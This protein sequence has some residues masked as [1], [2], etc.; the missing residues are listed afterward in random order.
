MRT[1]SND[2][3][4]EFHLVIKNYKKYQMKAKKIIAI[5]WISMAVYS[6]GDKNNTK[7]GGNEINIDEVVNSTSKDPNAKGENKCL[8]DYQS[9][10]DALIS[11]EDVLKVTGF[12]KAVMKTKLNKI[13]KDPGTH[14]FLFEFDNKRK[15]YIKQL[16]RKLEKEDIIAIRN[17]KPMSLTNFEQSYRALTDAEEQKAKEAMKDITEGN[18]D[19]PNADKAMKQAQQNMSKE[20]VN[21]VGGAIIDELKNVSQ[22]YVKVDGLGDAA[23]WNT[24][25]QELVVLQKGVQFEIMANINDNTETN[26]AAA[27]QL[28]KIVLD[29]CK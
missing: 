1:Q 14:E 20:D 21:K 5:L 25:T 7:Q 22:A 28:A 19:D 27:V 10:Y 15:Q 4:G 26:K 2:Y 8:L 23:V 11:A 3:F 29:K 24:Q 17:I 13:L 9:K 6:C 18:S 16:G 12:S